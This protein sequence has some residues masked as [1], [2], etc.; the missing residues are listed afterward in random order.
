M[1]LRHAVA[2]PP[3]TRSEQSTDR[4]PPD[5][6]NGW[7]RG[8]IVP[9]VRAHADRAVMAV[10]APPTRLSALPRARLAAVLLTD[11]VALLVV[12]VLTAR[13]WESPPRADLV[14]AVLLADGCCLAARAVVPWVSGRDRHGSAGTVVD[15]SGFVLALAA[16]LLPVALVP[17][18][19]LPGFAVDYLWARRRLFAVL[20][21]AA[22]LTAVT[23]VAA[24]VRVE[25][26]RTDAGQAAATTPRWALAAWTAAAV[27]IAGGFVWAPLGRWLVRGVPLD[28]STLGESVPVFQEAATAATAVLGATLWRIDPL[29]VVYL[30]GPVAVLQR[31]LYF[32]E[33]QLAARTDGKTGLL[34]Y[35]YF[36]E[37]ALRE[38]ARARRTGHPLALL[39]VDMDRLRDVNNTYGHQCGDQALLH[40]AEVIGAGARRYDLVCRFG[41]EEFLLL[42][43][44]TDVDGAAEIAERL[45]AAV[46]A[47][48]LHLADDLVTVTVSI[49]VAELAEAAVLAPRP[50]DD[51][52]ALLER[53]VAAADARVYA[54]MGAGRDRVVAG[55]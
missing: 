42:L 20:L 48:P 28:V 39:V 1:R 38:I 41:G 44:G 18:A 27:M 22:V 50:D 7:L 5:R 52:Q 15:L 17:L 6:P 9:P 34:N 46:R 8:V 33:V 54:A 14:T 30:A 3:V 53:L 45:R 19:A 35:R 4:F 2:S 47:L 55:V 43:P 37:C 10:P 16:L 40:V 11:A 26:A 21:N 49:G 12:V 32:R 31:L 24:L 51:A 23:Q 36:E 13:S 25:L 29:L